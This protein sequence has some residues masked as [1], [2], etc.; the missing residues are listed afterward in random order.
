MALRLLVLGDLDRVAQER[1]ARRRV[2]TRC[3]R[4]SRDGHGQD[5]MAVSARSANVQVNRI[6]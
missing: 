5:S 6:A 2:Q 4:T 3:K 1:L